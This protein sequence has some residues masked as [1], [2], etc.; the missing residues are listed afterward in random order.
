MDTQEY[1]DRPVI[2]RFSLALWLMARGHEPLR[3]EMSPNNDGKPV[4]IYTFS[5]ALRGEIETYQRTKE[6]LRTL[7]HGK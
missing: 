4:E 3:A 5:P 7:A 1:L 6:R 2:A